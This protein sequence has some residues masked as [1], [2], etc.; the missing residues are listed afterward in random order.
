VAPF[1]EQ[2]PAEIARLVKVRLASSTKAAVKT[3]V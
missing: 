2:A 3:R 1:P